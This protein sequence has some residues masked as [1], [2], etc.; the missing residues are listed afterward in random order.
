MANRIA[1]NP[2]AVIIGAATGIGA[3]LSAAATKRG[4]LIARADHSQLEEDD[5]GLVA[6][7]DVRN[8]T[9]LEEFSEAVF[10][11]YGRVDLLFNNAGVMRP[12]PIWE[13]DREHLDAVIDI[14]LGGVINAVRAFV[15]RMLDSGRSG[16][17]VNT[18]SLAGLIPAPG[19]SSYCVS[20]HAVVALSETLAI[21]LAGV[22]SEIGVSVVCPGAVSTNI[23]RSAASALSKS[24]N[25]TAKTAVDMMAAGLKAVGVAPA[26]VAETIFD[27]INNGDFCIWAT[28]ESPEPFRARC[29]AIASGKMA[30]FSKWGHEDNVDG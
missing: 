25:D 4:Y 7:L 9:D 20:K 21:D 14:N 12:G 2:V 3:A 27:A 22:G 24:D 13:Q 8:A 28:G 18:A 6:R 11:K 15:P 5:R 1:S 19:L 10:Q 16:R 17:I 30:G 26:T 29:E 23:M